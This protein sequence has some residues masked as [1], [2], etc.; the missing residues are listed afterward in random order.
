[1]A[2]TPS[3]LSCTTGVLEDGAGISSTASHSSTSP[4]AKKPAR[5]SIA[6]PEGRPDGDSD[7]KML[8]MLGRNVR[9]KA[10]DGYVAVCEH[11]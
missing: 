7:R 5:L 2:T 10:T 8:F 9:Q 11:E 6:L 3:S 4:A 1:M